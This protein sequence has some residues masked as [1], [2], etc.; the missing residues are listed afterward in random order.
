MWLTFPTR[1]KP[2]SVLEVR[3]KYELEVQVNKEQVQKEHQLRVDDIVQR[4]RDVPRHKSVAVCTVQSVQRPKERVRIQSAEKELHREVPSLTYREIPAGATTVTQEKLTPHVT[5]V[6]KN[7]VVQKPKV[8]KT[9]QQVSLVADG[10]VKQP[11]LVKKSVQE[12]RLAVKEVKKVKTHKLNK[13]N[14]A[15]Q[16]V[17][18]QKD[19]LGRETLEVEAVKVDKPETVRKDNIIVRDVSVDKE[20]QREVL[21]IKDK[22]VEKIVMVEKAVPVPKVE[23]VQ[24]VTN[25]VT[26]LE[27][28]KKVKVSRPVAVEEIVEAIIERPKEVSRTFEVPVE[29]VKYSYKDLEIPVDKLVMKQQDVQVKVDKVVHVEVPVEVNLEKVT[30]KVVLQ[31]VPVEVAIETVKYH[32]VTENVPVERVEYKEVDK[33]IEIDKLV[34]RRVDVDVTVQNIVEKVEIKD[35]DV[36]VPVEKIEYIEGQVTEVPVERLVVKDKETRVSY[37]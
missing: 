4:P 31:Q 8:V 35:R 15:E 22:S 27:V 28:K 9:V 23:T 25:K 12:E 34:E 11:E 2:I 36:D 29:T 7:Y 1:R 13:Q 18:L 30:E 21:Q 6:N 24:I 10:I 17:T 5:A 16:V 33:V 3:T 14:A 37:R 32:D 26:D 20:A 19:C